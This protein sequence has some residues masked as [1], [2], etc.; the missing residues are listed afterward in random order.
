VSGVTLT[1]RR[2]S[3]K[4]RHI[5]FVLAKLKNLICKT[6]SCC[7]IIQFFNVLLFWR[8]KTGIRGNVV[9]KTRFGIFADPVAHLSTLSKKR[10]FVY[11][12]TLA[13]KL[14]FNLRFN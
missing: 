4:D 10:L 6:F 5:N 13:K 1:Q 3:R 7:A 2:N 11:Y 9:R 12:E 8:L 14:K